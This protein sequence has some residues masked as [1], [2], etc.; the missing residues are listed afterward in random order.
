MQIRRFNNTRSSIIIGEPKNLSATRSAIGAA[1]ETAKDIQYYFKASQILRTF[2]SSSYSGNL[3]QRLP[4]ISRLPVT[5][6]DSFLFHEI[7]I[8]YMRITENFYFSLQDLPKR[9][10]G[11]SNIAE[12]HVK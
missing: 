9:S 7:Q 12:K 2:L 8:C 1:K 3:F 5:T 10:N 11:G 4:I 6:R